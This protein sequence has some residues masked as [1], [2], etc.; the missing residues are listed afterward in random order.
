[1]SIHE[2]RVD[3][4]DEEQRE[5]KPKCLVGEERHIKKSEMHHSP[6][7][8]KSEQCHTESEDEVDGVKEALLSL[9]DVSI[10]YGLLKKRDGICRGTNCEY[11]SKRA[12]ERE[13]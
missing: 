10:E 2:N 3:I 6:E 12:Y 4:N 11:E 8:R 1:M 9:I 7:N 5:L 13:K